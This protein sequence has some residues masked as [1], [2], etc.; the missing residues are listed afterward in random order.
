MTY[1]KRPVLMITFIMAIFMIFNVT[2]SAKK[3]GWLGVSI[4]SVK[5][6][7]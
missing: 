3:K 4:V 5:R 6:R 7:V 1:I 2:A